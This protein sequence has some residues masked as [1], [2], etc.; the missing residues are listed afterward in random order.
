MSEVTQSNHEEHHE[1]NYMAVFGALALLT[2]LEIGITYLPIPRGL[3]A[4]AL[5]SMALFKAGLVALY[6]MHLISERTTLKM[7]CIIPLILG[8]ILFIGVAPDALHKLLR[9]VGG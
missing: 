6:F 8:A 9:P 3:I 5:V 2:A 1:P 4:F 7:I